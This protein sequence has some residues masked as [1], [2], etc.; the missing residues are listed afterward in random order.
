MSYYKPPKDG[1]RRLLEIRNY[2]A[3]VNQVQRDAERTSLEVPTE[4]QIADQIIR[5]V[6]L[7]NVKKATFERLMVDL[8]DT[9]GRDLTRDKDGGG[10]LWFMGEMCVARSSGD[11]YQIRPSFLDADL[12][13][14]DTIKD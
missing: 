13:R 8:Y 12:N 4:E 14:F 10:F 3:V 9:N 7:I 2:T 1:L 5:E 6:P 11:Q